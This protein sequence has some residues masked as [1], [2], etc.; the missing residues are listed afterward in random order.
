MDQGPHSQH[1]IFFV[2]YQSANKLECYITL[3]WKG[4]PGT[5]TQAHRAH[6]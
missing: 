6:Q 3:S 4:L 5:N 1:F 2:T